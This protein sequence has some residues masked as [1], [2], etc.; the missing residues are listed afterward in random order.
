MRLSVFALSLFLF[1]PPALAEET[2]TASPAAR[3]FLVYLTADSDVY[4][5]ARCPRLKG[6]L[7]AIP[8]GDVDASMK[9]CST[10]KLSSRKPEKPPDPT[11]KNVTNKADCALSIASFSRS[12]RTDEYQRRFVSLKARVANNDAAKKVKAW[13]LTVA[14]MDVFGTPQT[15]LQLTS[16][17][18]SIKPST[19]ELAEFEFEDNQFIEGETYDI[20]MAYSPENLK[21]QV[22][23]CQVAFAEP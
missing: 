10:C 6:D 3:D 4:H 5:L 14:I 1:V 23:E 21:L 15:K 8:F 12:T 7:R 20:L 19:S 22:V 13:R 11:A 2:P 9:P 18:S 16:G 17:Q